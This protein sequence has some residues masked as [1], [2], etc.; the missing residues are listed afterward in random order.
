MTCVQIESTYIESFKIVIK[1]S[2]WYP[3]AMVTS[4][5]PRKEAK[6]VFIWPKYLKIEK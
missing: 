2:K 4:Q 5:N 3:I 6:N 1:N